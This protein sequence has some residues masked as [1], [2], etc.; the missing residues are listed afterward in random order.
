MCDKYGD[1]C[2]DK[3]EQCGDEPASGDKPFPGFDMNFPEP[4]SGMNLPEPPYMNYPKPP[5]MNFPEP[6]YMN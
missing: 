1:C 3:F 5:Y 2:N 4:R 6:P